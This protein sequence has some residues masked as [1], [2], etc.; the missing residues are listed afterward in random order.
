MMD[1]RNDVAQC[2]SSLFDGGYTQPHT[3]AHT[4]ATITQDSGDFGL[5][6]HVH[7][8]FPGDGSGHAL[9][10]ARL[11]PDAKDKA[12][13]HYMVVRDTYI[14]G[15]VI[16][17][18]LQR[19]LNRVQRVNRYS[20]M[21]IDQFKAFV[22]RTAITE[23]PH[24]ISGN[25]R[26][27]D[28]IHGAVG[29]TVAFCLASTVVDFGIKVPLTEHPAQVAS[30]ARWEH[31]LGDGIIAQ[32]C[33]GA[34]SHMGQP[35][36]NRA[37]GFRH[38]VRALG[39][40]LT[41]AS[42]LV[43]SCAATVQATMAPK[44]ESSSAGN[45]AGRPPPPDRPAVPA[46]DVGLAELAVV[47]SVVRVAIKRG[48]AWTHLFSW[49]LKKLRPEQVAAIWA[50]LTANDKFVSVLDKV[51][52][53]VWAVDVALIEEHLKRL[54]PALSVAFALVEAG[55]GAYLSYA[56]GNELAVVAGG[57]MAS[58]LTRL[59]AHVAL[60]VLPFPLGVAAH[61][62]W[63][64]SVE[65][66]R[67]TAFDRGTESEAAWL[68]RIHTIAPVARD[69]WLNNLTIIRLFSAEVLQ[70][71]QARQTAHDIAPDPEEE[72]AQ[73]DRA[74][75][76]TAAPYT[77]DEP[78]RHTVAVTENGDL[79]ASQFKQLVEILDDDETS[80]SDGTVHRQSKLVAFKCDANK[81]HAEPGAG[82][83][84]GVGVAMARFGQPPP[85]PAFESKKLEQI[86]DSGFRLWSNTLLADG[87]EVRFLEL[88]ELLEYVVTSDH[89]TMWKVRILD[90]IHKAYD[91]VGAEEKH[92][93][94]IKLDEML[95]TKIALSS[96][97]GHLRALKQR[98]IGPIIPSDT[99]LWR[100]AVALKDALDESI[101]VYET[102]IC[103]I[104]L[105]YTARPSHSVV[106]ILQQRAVDRAREISSK[107]R[108]T[109]ADVFILLSHGDDLKAIYLSTQT[110]KGEQW[111]E[112]PL[113]IALCDAS[114]RAEYQ[115]ALSR[116]TQAMARDTIFELT[117]Y[118]DESKGLICVK[119]R[120]NAVHPDLKVSVSNL[121]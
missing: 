98:V 96:L 52:L 35:A 88:P 102:A 76:G 46:E 109:S 33:A 65:V 68:H 99:P 20:E 37:E 70:Q 71:T 83:L 41:G 113:D 34:L 115:S 4:L 5:V 74:P 77:G 101:T 60:S 59:L 54:F 19:N 72:L 15:G 11:V 116:F 117:D 78:K 36:A 56:E 84:D 32:L 93:F 95:K 48:R 12:W 27:L 3:A 40:F 22:T 38:T 91:G 23:L 1:W 28:R 119:F 75:M 13:E 14:E 51:L 16:T 90:W 44:P 63:D 104:L 94:R 26:L 61:A 57:F 58:F 6:R 49:F 42:G 121:K 45:S 2:A 30:R 21:A 110:E 62:L 29:D 97:G 53:A 39:S 82:P 79:S 31:D 100:Y 92:R 80:G 105:V 18:G 55:S 66:V 103:S 108:G 9:L 112:M 73:G 87:V 17:L 67:Q 85:Y 47:N 25:R 43:K 118:V 81:F 10:I 7:R 50:W 8:V 89:T 24:Q 106:A 64:W 114:S 107:N 86:M 111:A 120:P 69:V